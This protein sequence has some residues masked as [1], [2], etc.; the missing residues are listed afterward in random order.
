MDKKNI[1]LILFI[2]FFF[3]SG[4][5]NID[6]SEVTDEDL[7]R[8]SN[9]TVVCNEPYIRVGIECCLDKNNNS[10]C[11]KDEN[12]FT[13][14][15]NEE[16]FGQSISEND[17]ILLN[18]SSENIKEEIVEFTK[19]TLNK[20]FT[21][22]THKEDYP[23]KGNLYIVGQVQLSWNKIKDAKCYNIMN[24][25]KNIF[26]DIESEY[27]TTYSTC[28][29]KEYDTLEYIA[30]GLSPDTV[31]SYKIVAIDEY[32]QEINESNEVIVKF[33]DWCVDNDGSLDENG[34]YKNGYTADYGETEKARDYCIDEDTLVENICNYAPNELYKYYRDLKEYNCEFGCSNG[35]CL[36]DNND[37]DNDDI[38]LITTERLEG[39]LIYLK[40]SQIIEVNIELLDTQC[41]NINNYNLIEGINEISLSNCQITSGNIYYVNI[42]VDE[43]I[44]QSEVLARTDSSELEVIEVNL[45][46]ERLEGD[47]IYVRSNIADSIQIDILNTTCNSIVNYNVIEGVNEIS[48]SNCNIKEGYMYDLILTTDNSIFQETHISRGDSSILVGLELEIERLEGDYIYIKSNLNSQINVQIQ[49]SNCYDI[50]NYNIVEGVN[51]IS[52]NNCNIEQGSIYNVTVSTD[53]SNVLQELC[54]AKADSDNLEYFTSNVEIER[55]EI[56]R[57]YIKNTASKDFIDVDIEIG[58]ECNLYDATLSSNSVS[59]IIFNNCNITMNNLYDVS[60]F[61]YKNQKALVKIIAK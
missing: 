12:N 20:D 8:I 42:E 56:D 17:N 47:F 3:F 6:L 54:F 24:K 35:A 9:K 48:L 25:G 21:N 14:K 27:Y 46:V 50:L 52:L 34:I 10:I 44:F 33:Q 26:S 41:E 59:E 43:K 36:K 53:S 22:I 13:D 7:Q 2:I 18:I 15:L 1:F 19:L 16:E 11:D 45:S 23:I 38:I 61:N 28:W 49:D 5:S 58:N 40:S 57:V 51:M 30:N 37:Y 32:N 4:C 31:F 60:V 55:L 39:D 29:N